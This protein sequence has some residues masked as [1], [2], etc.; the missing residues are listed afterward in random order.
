VQL[1]LDGHPNH[2]VHVSRLMERKVVSWSLMRRP[3]SMLCSATADLSGRTRRMLRYNPEDSHLHTHRRENLKS[4]S[5]HC[6]ISGNGSDFSHQSAGRYLPTNL[7]LLTIQTIT[8]F[9]VDR[10][11]MEDRGV[12]ERMRSKWVV[13]KFAGNVSAG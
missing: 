2:P 11:H 3:R 10:D 1:N 6:F 12:D 9:T 8:L 13:G 7:P 5:S 4:N